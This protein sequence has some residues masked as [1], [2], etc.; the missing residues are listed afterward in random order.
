MLENIKA[1]TAKFARFFVC[2]FVFI[3]DQNRTFS[4]EQRMEER[5]PDP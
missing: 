3:C 5:K 4:E 2:L 1:T